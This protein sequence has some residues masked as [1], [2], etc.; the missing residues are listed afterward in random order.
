MKNT[1]LFLRYLTDQ[2]HLRRRGSLVLWYDSVLK[3][4]TLHWQNELNTNNRLVMNMDA[5]RGR[6]HIIFQF[7]LKVKLLTFF[8]IKNV[9]ITSTELL[10]MCGIKV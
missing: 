5:A 1:P 3:D 4:G 10:E 9:N 7:N 6:E 2:M 8:D